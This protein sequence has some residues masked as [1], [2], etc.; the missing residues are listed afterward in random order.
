MRSASFLTE[1]VVWAQMDDPD[2]DMDVYCDKLDDLLQKRIGEMNK[3]R[4]KIS[5][6]QRAIQV[7]E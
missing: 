7:S 1:S 5:Q 3:L 2:A 6:Y 4:A